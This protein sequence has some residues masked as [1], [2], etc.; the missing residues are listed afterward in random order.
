LE[1][2]SGSI[3]SKDMKKIIII[4]SKYQH[5]SYI[6]SDEN[7]FSIYEG[8]VNKGKR[9]GVGILKSTNSPIVYSG[10]WKMGKR[11]GKVKCVT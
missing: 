5:F 4:H 2:S 6:L 7:D 9:H 11:Y 8:Q 3:L 1:S 10:Q